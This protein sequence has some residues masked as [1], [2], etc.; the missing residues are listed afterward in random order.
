MQTALL[1]RPYRAREA[2]RA[3]GEG[4]GEGEL[5]AVVSLHPLVQRTTQVGSRMSYCPGTDCQALAIPV[6]VLLWLASWIGWVL[7]HRLRRCPSCLRQSRADGHCPRSVDRTITDSKRRVVSRRARW[8]LADHRRHNRTD[9]GDTIP[10]P[11][12]AYL[13]DVKCV[14]CCCKATVGDFM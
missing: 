8:S 1:R 5:Q 6:A 13:L 12:S 4:G 3:L 7:C 2:P 14:Q 9:C 10:P 11:Q